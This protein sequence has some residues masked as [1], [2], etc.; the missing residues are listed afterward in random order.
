MEQAPLELGGMWLPW[1]TLSGDL[2]CNPWSYAT[3][4]CLE[5]GRG[6]LPWEYNHMRSLD[7]GASSSTI[8]A[9]HDGH[10]E[11][12]AED[13][14]KE[15]HFSLAQHV[16]EIDAAT[17]AE[18]LQPLQD[19]PVLL[20]DNL[21]HVVFPED[22]PNQKQKYEKFWQKC[23]VLDT[24]AYTAIYN[25]DGNEGSKPIA[26]LALSHRPARLNRGRLHQRGHDHALIQ[27]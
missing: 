13:A 21:V 15:G 27:T 7:T 22:M 6:I 11:L 25:L 18:T 16:L 2:L 12:A 24:A 4:G 1:T 19:T 17:E 26:D 9:V 5:N 20:L 10:A 3:Y 14:V 8:H 23:I